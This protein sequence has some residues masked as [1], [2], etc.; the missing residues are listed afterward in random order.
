MI[1]DFESEFTNSRRLLPPPSLPYKLIPIGLSFGTWK[2]S[3][4]RNKT[5]TS[6]FRT[7]YHRKHTF[8]FLWYENLED[9]LEYGILVSFIAFGIQFYALHDFIRVSSTFKRRWT[10]GSWNETFVCIRA[11]TVV[12]DTPYEIL[13]IWSHNSELMFLFLC[14]SVEKLKFQVIN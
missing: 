10:K 8:L 12:I 1:C 2:L 3:Y 11:L 4:R 14:D 5:V 13:R 7:I 9:H 6:V